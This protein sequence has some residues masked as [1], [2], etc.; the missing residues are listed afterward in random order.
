MPQIISFIARSKL[1]LCLFGLLV[2][3][4]LDDV[5]RD[6]SGGFS[7]VLAAFLDENRDDD[8]R[9]AA[10]RITDKPRIVFKFFLFANAIACP[11]ADDLG[12]PGF[13]TELNPSEL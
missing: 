3:I 10:R 13:S 9:I 4:G 12:G 8:F 2:V 7:S 11:V 1:S 5:A 6:R